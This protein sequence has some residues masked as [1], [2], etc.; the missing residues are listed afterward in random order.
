MNGNEL[1]V[2]LMKQLGNPVTFHTHDWKSWVS[3]ELEK[4]FL[5]VYDISHN[6]IAIRS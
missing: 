2:V 3:V 5:M 6:S 1:G 4:D